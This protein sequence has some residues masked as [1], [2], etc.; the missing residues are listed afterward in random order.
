MY[1]VRRLNLSSHK[2]LCDKLAQESGKLYS[3]T[4][5]FFWRTV[6]K[7]ELWLKPSSLMRLFNSN[8]MHAHSADASIQQFF[9][10]LSSWRTV[11]KTIPEAKPPKR[12]RKYSCVVWKNTAIRI[13]DQQLILSN[14]K[15]TES[16]IIPW[17]HSLTPVQTT[18][19]WTGIGYELVFCYKEDKPETNYNPE[20]PVGIDI[21]QIHV[22]ATS[23]GTIVNG[24]LLRSIRQGRQRSC[25]ILE[26]RMSKKK[27]GSKRWK[28]LREAKRRLCRKVVNKARDILHKYTTGLVMYLKEKGYNA[29]VVGDLTGYRVENNC[30]SVRNQENHAWLYSQISWYLKYKWVRLGL[31]YVPQEESHTSKTCPACGSRKKPTGREYKCKCGFVGHRDLVGATNILRKYLGTFGAEIAKFCEANKYLGA[32]GKMFPVD[33]LMARASGVRFNPH[34]SVAHGFLTA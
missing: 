3:N 16:L 32:F 23:E 17:E 12:L 10:A 2:D 13:K 18:L 33:A 31:R 27:K 1:Y 15:I 30:G 20:Q 6:R 8:N 19:R 9:N 5:K 4:V 26:Q 22:A 25:S 34:I 21:G 24:R 14:G 11:R 28:R 7:K 29:L